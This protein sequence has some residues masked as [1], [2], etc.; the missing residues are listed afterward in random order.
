MSPTYLVLT[1]LLLA[2][3]VYIG[4]YVRDSFIRPFVGDML[5]VVLLYCFL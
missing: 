3:E 4:L 2:V 1:L 5:V